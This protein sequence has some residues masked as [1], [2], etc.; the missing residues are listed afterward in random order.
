MARLQHLLPLLG[1][2][3]TAVV[4]LQLVPS[5][6]LVVPFSG[7]AFHL[8]KCKDGEGHNRLDGDVGGAGVVGGKN[9][10]AAAAFSFQNGTF[11]QLQLRAWDGWCWQPFWQ[12]WWWSK[13]RKKIVRAGVGNHANLWGGLRRQVAGR[14][15]SAAYQ[16]SYTKYNV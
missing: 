7:L 6:F 12:W 8:V 11:V 10:T 4:F 13:E 16:S 1:S 9:R 14:T 15:T 3:P 2:I 5:T